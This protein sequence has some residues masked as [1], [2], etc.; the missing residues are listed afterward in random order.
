M[1][2]RYKIAKRSLENILTFVKYVKF[3]CNQGFDFG[4][5]IKNFKLF[6]FLDFHF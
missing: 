4:I 1:F 3:V 5:F 6:G 2:V